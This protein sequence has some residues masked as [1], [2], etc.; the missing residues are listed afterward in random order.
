MKAAGLAV[1]TYPYFDAANNCVN[2]PAMMDRLQHVQAG[3]TV[4]LH[5]SCHNPTGADLAPD[6]WSQVA[7]L[8]ERL[9][10]LPL[11]DFAYQ[12]FGRGLDEDATGLRLLVERLPETMIAS[13]YSKNFGLYNERVG[14]L[15]IIARTSAVAEATLSQVK[16]VITDY[17]NRPHMVRKSFLQSS[18]RLN[19]QSGRS[20]TRCGAESGCAGSSSKVACIRCGRDLITRRSKRHV[21]LYGFDEGAGHRLP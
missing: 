2:F 9:G 21:L 13:S 1:E 7:G 5:G 3:D 16:I 8:L 12:G 19:W 14:A 20:S 4:L 17:S 18:I 6:Q 15:T 11:I 10:A